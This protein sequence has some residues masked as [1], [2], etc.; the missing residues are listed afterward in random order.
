MKDNDPLS[1][2]ALLVNDEIDLSRRGLLSALVTKFGGV[3]GVADAAKK[4][5][6]HSEDSPNVQAKLLDIVISGIVDLDQDD[7]PQIPEDELMAF[8]RKFISEEANGG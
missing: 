7:T 5:Y 3:A 8:A 4:L 6:D 2:A 1:A